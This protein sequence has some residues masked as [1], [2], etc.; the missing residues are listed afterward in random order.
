MSANVNRTDP[1]RNKR[2]LIVAANPGTIPVT[3]SKTSATPR[4]ASPRTPAPA[5]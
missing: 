2:V 3:G 1:S 4:C 5:R